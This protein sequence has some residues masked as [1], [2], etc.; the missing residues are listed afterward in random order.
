MAETARF[1]MEVHSRGLG[2]ALVKPAAAKGGAWVRYADHASTIEALQEWQDRATTAESE[3]SALRKRVEELEGAL[4]PFGRVET[5]DGLPDGFLRIPD[6]H[7]VLFNRTGDKLEVAVTVGDIRH[8]RTL[9]E[10]GNRR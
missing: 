10:G 6:S 9:T 5:A 3:A 7:A 8:A 2:R 4:R 1:R